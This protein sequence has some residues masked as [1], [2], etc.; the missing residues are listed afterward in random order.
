M[1]IATSRIAN[2]CPA[3]I[4]EAL[5]APVDRIGLAK[6]PHLEALIRAARHDSI[7]D[8]ADAVHLL[9]DLHGRHPGLLDQALLRCPAGASRDWL[10]QACDGFERERLYLIRL[11]AAAGPLPSTP[12]AAASEA[13]L[14]AQR[15]ALDTLALSERRGCALGASAAL[16]GDW[17]GIRPLLDRAAVRLGIDSPLSTLPEPASTSA[18]LASIAAQ[19]SATQRAIGFGVEQMLLQHRGLFDLLEARASARAEQ[20]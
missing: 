3:T 2:R 17:H 9:C 14:A 13:A 11:S 1:A 7:R 8:L 18:A 5:L 16:I 4:A 19:D 6:H 12:G 15:H 10:E 20:V